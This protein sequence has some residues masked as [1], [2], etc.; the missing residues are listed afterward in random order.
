MPHAS[1]IHSWGD[2]WMGGDPD[3]KFKAILGRIRDIEGGLT[4]L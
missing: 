1:D 2:G 3:R 4:G